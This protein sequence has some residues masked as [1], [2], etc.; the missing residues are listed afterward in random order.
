MNGKVIQVSVKAGS[1]PDPTTGDLVTCGEMW[2]EP[3]DW[4]AFRSLL[5][6]GMHDV[7]RTQVGVVILDGTKRAGKDDEVVEFSRN[8]K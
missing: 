8:W 5:V 6:A 3:K 7:R 4:H 1:N 2:M